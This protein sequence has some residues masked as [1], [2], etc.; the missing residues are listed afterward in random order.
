M[1]FNIYFSFIKYLLL[2]IFNLLQMDKNINNFTN[3]H[4]YH[5]HTVNPAFKT[6]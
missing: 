3:K 5:Q 2:L 4:Y 6:N 1:E